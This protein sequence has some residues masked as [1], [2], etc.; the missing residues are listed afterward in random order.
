MQTTAKSLGKY[1][2]CMREL[3]G[4]LRASISVT[5]TRRGRERGP[6]RGY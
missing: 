3:G 2:V 1:G 5:D 4:F 6:D